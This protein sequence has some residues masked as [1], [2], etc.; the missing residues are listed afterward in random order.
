MD[1]GDRAVQR[2]VAPSEFRIVEANC[3]GSDETAKCDE[4]AVKIMLQ[5]T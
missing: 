3:V 4:P 2:A 1:G 5:V